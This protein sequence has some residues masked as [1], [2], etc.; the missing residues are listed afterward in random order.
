MCGGC[1]HSFQTSFWS[2]VVFSFSVT[3]NYE[4]ISYV[5]T[6][7]INQLDTVVIS[8]F[9]QS[10]QSSILDKAKD[11]PHTVVQTSIS[12]AKT[13][14]IYQAHAAGCKIQEIMQRDSYCSICC[15]SSKYSGRVWRP[16]N[17]PNR[18]LQVKDEHWSAGKTSKHYIREGNMIFSIPHET[19]HV[20]KIQTRTLTC[21][22]L[23]R[24]R[25]SV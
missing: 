14:K 22:S 21:Q 17:I 25:L 19:Q 12:W 18:C 13:C 3:L 8:T 15:Y 7:L 20:Y 4:Y 16:G 11:N 2:L 9:F 23:Q 6:L 1:N 10:Y 5:T 24:E